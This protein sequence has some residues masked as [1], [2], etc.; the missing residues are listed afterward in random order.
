MKFKKPFVRLKPKKV[1]KK[2][3][4]QYKKTNAKRFV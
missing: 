2:T 4:R 3:K 1:K